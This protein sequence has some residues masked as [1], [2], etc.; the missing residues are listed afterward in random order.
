MSESADR[1]LIFGELRDRGGEP[2]DVC[3]CTI[4]RAPHSYTGENTAELQCHGSPTVLRAA[5]D[6]LFALGARQAAPGEFTKRAFL[7]G[8]MELCA[9]EAVA[10]II[11]AETVGVRQ[12]RRRT[13]L[14]RDKPQGGRDIFRADRHQLA[15]SRGAGLPRRGYRRLPAESYEGG[16]TSALTELSGCRR[17]MSAASL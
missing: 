2:L 14:R 8:R 11:D 17:A 9:A 1:R 10:D 5:L 6:E 3:L 13:A 16:L 15:L 7:N 12:E 4:S